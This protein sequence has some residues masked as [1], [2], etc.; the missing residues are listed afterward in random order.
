L[1]EKGFLF[2]TPRGALF[3]P[4]SKIFMPWD[5]AIIFGYNTKAKHHTTT[6]KPRQI[7]FHHS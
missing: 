4:R 5:F 1:L 2:S 7:G 6:K 3:F